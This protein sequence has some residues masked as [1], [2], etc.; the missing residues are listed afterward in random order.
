MDKVILKFL[1]KFKEPRKAKLTEKNKGG[2]LTLCNFKNSIKLPLLRWCS[3]GL[4][5]ERQEQWNS[6]Q[7]SEIDPCIYEQIIF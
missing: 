4:L 1:G 3:N 2:R 5:S 6:I 7:N